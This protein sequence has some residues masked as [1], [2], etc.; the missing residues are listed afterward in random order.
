MATFEYQALTSGGR[1][2]TG[3]LEAASRE[4]AGGLLEEMKLK[5]NSLTQAKPAKVRT[6]I[7]RNEFILFN[8]QLASLT[9]AGLPLE[10]GLRELAAD[11]SSRSMRRLLN[12]IAE[13]LEKGMPIEQVFEKRKK[14]FPPLYGRIL[15]AGVE[16]GRLSEMLI[17]M[18]RHLEMAG[19]TRR[20]VIEAVSYPAVVLALA[21]VL[22]TGIFTLIIPNFREIYSDFDTNLP[23]LTRFFLALTN[24]NITHFWVAAAVL[25]AGTVLMWKAMSGFPA[26]RVFEE[27]LIMRVPIL[28]RVYHNSILS[29]LADA[30]ALLIGTGCDVGQAMTLGAD[31]SGSDRLKRECKILT[32]QIE[33]GTNLMEAGQFSGTIPRMFFYSMQ[34]GAQRN[35]LQDNLYSLS[36]MYA[37]QARGSQAKLSVALMPTLIIAL[38]IIIGFIVLAMFMPMVSMIETLS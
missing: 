18:N 25:V 38:G 35:E 3:T 1:L 33:K 13:E 5:V 36:D 6:P 7:G 23:A 11:I 28:G 17:S 8:Q 12:D 29:R 2:M 4:Q 32:E 15:K 27:R 14:H 19:Q 10:K 26:G 24:I 9:K 16:T 34:L 20:I 37:Q 21:A 22:V 31:A 30:M